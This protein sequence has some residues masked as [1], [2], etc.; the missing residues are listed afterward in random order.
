MHNFRPI[1]SFHMHH[2]QVI[3][4]V[5]YDGLRHR[6]ND[7]QETDAGFG[8]SPLPHQSRIARNNS[9]RGVI[10]GRVLKCFTANDEE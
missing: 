7:S 2:I 5:G 3:N 10:I 4:S 1:G 6:L 9:V 8:A